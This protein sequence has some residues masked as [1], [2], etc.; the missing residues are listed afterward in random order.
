[1]PFP[2]ASTESQVALNEAPEIVEQLPAISYFVYQ[3]KPGD[4]I[5]RLAGEYGVDQDT[6]IS[7]NHIKN[8][9][10]IQPG[11]YLKIPSERGILYTVREDGETIAG[12]AAKYE[13]SPERCAEIARVS[14]TEPLKAGAEIFVPGGKLDDMILKEINGDLFQRPIKMFWRYSSPYGYRWSPITPDLR[15]FHTGVDL[16]GPNHTPVYAA[17][18]GSVTYAGWDDTYGN[19]VKI[20]HHS[21]Y[22]T[23]YGHMDD[24]KVKVGQWVTTRTQIGI[25][26]N[27]GFSTG[28]HL[29][30]TVFKNGKTV[31]P[32]LL[33]K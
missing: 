4:M 21:G 16:V 15:T 1:M 30:F 26:G 2:P 33:M 6:L 14:L 8:T 32:R 28:P 22:V 3:V 24:I 13:V 23:L 29:H 10:T 31:N 12:I 9:R 25:L 7:V 5:S 19:C 11:E 20:A 17:M 18:D 27:T